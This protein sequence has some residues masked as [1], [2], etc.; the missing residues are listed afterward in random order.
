MD[1]VE[2]RA[3]MKYLC[4]K[5]MSPKEIHDF[6]K[7]LGNEFPSYSMVEKGAAKFKWAADFR[8]GREREEDYEWSWRPKEATTVKNVELVH[9]L[10]MCDR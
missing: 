2:V 9:S 3:V 5:D 8:R 6:I 10:I 1:I 4:K 7:T